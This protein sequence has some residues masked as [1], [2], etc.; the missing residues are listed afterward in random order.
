MPYKD[1]ET[2]KRY[3]KSYHEAYYARNKASR[4]AQIRGRKR[5]IRDVINE[6][7]RLQGCQRCEEDH[8][9]ALDFHHVGQKDYL[10]SKMIS[11]GLAIESIMSEAEKCILLCANCHRLEHYAEAQSR[12]EV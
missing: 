6:Y 1:P 12:D 8:P 11:D 4:M 7:K 5:Q 9:R 3:Q 10:I 2:K